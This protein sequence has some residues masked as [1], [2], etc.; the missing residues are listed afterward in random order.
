MERSAH[1]TWH[2]RTLDQNHYRHVIWWTVCPSP[3][4]DH[5]GRWL[6]WTT[7]VRPQAQNW[8]LRGWSLESTWS[9]AS[10][11]PRR[12]D[13]SST[14]HPLSTSVVQPV[15]SYWT[16]NTSLCNP[17]SQL[18]CV[19]KTEA[20]VWTVVYVHSQ[21]VSLQINSNKCGEMVDIWNLHQAKHHRRL[22]TCQKSPFAFCPGAPVAWLNVISA[23]GSEASCLGWKYSHTHACIVC[24]C[25]C[26]HA[27][28]VHACV[29]MLVCACLTIRIILFFTGS[30]ISFM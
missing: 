2:A 8:N 11:P 19:V 9:A 29:Y 16:E 5:T 13:T 22:Q 27:L 30:N 26:V 7:V 18:F 6:V 23:G 14:W 15:L 10:L 4:A 20:I 24:A 12:E 28:C 21:N 1:L 17:I 25:L 3:H